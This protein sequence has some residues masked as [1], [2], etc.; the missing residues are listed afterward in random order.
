MPQLISADVDV[1]RGNVSGEVV[2]PGDPAYDEARR[3]WN[4]GIDRRPA[5]IV[6][7]TDAHD[8]SAAVGF[9][10]AH[11]LEI[12]VRGG[13]HSTGGNGVVDDG[14]MIELSRI[15]GVEVD[16]AA[17]RCR[18]GGGATLAERDTATQEHGL[19]TTAGIVGHT[20]VGGLTLGGGMG[21]LTRKHGLAV[22]NLLSVEIVTADGEIRTASTTEN[23]DLFWAVRGGGGNFGVVTSFEFA[24]HPV[25]PMVSLGMF[26]WP[27]DKGPDVMRLARDLFAGM[28][29]D[30]N[31]LIAGVHVPPAPFV[32][33]EHRGTPAYGL[34][35]T[36]FDAEAEH[37]QVVGRIRDQLPPLVEMVT[38]IPYIQLQQMFD[39]ANA[40]GFLAYDKATYLEDLTEGA[41]AVIAAHLPRKTSP[42]SAMFLY[43]LDG[44]YSEVGEA[45]TAFPGGRTP[46]YG[47]FLV[48]VADNQELYE[49]D[50]AWVRSFW[51]AIQ[52]HA[53][54]VGSYLN[55]EAEYTDDRVRGS[56]GP[57]KYERLARIKHRYDPDNVFHLNANIPPAAQPPRQRE[58]VT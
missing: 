6:R 11:D 12:A 47:M 31:I 34:L 24:L 45:D 52:P 13:A 27:L 40:W 43:R 14:L 36:G 10:R 25:G 20:G 28:S 22:D 38:P 55:A 37:Q 44:A 51:D 26:F 49:A 9:A 56:Y 39:E 1:L 16:P 48:A 4:G 5:V 15:N 53:M 19:A 42:G 18:V 30:I 46:R 58:P 7:C 57:E 21:W 50:R 41:I 35:V 29:T 32:P 54:G 3:V 8:V 17:R 33:E 23:P 2:V